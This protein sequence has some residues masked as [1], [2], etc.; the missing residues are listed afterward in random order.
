MWR[1]LSQVHVLHPWTWKQIQQARSDGNEGFDIERRKTLSWRPLLRW[2]S[3]WDQQRERIVSELLM[4]TGWDRI[5]KKQEKDWQRSIW[6]QTDELT[7]GKDRWVNYVTFDPV[8]NTVNIQC[9]SFSFSIMHKYNP[10]MH[11][12]IIRCILTPLHVLSMNI[13]LNDNLD[14]GQVLSTLLGPNVPTRIINPEI[15]SII[16][17]ANSAHEKNSSINI[18]IMA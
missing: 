9:R 14:W 18:L 13:N 6:C 17:P 10:Q 1:R 8:F 3:V 2:I 11:G 16:G 12:L 5:M 7:H 15:T 4:C